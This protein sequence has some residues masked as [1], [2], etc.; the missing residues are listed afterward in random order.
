MDQGEAKQRRPAEAAQPARN[1]NRLGR[2]RVVIAVAGSIGIYALVRPLFDRFL[3]PGQDQAAIAIIVVLAS[4]WILRELYGQSRIQQSY[5]SRLEAELEL[6]RNLVDS[7]P[8]DLF[9]K[10]LDGRFIFSNRAMATRAR[11]ESD[12]DLIG[13]TDFDFFPTEIAASY[14][15]DDLGVV[16]TGVPLIGK[17]ERTLE[18]QG[19]P[20]WISTSKYPLRDGNNKIVGV[21]GISQDLTTMVERR[22]V[23]RAL[24]DSVPDFLYAKDRAGRF[25]MANRAVA[26]HMGVKSADDLLG[27]TDFEFYPEELARGFWEDEQAIMQSGRR[28]INKEEV[29]QDGAGQTK[30]TI[31]TKLC[32]RDRE[33]EVI[34]I[35]GMGHD[36]TSRKIAERELIAAREQALRASEAEHRNAESLGEAV[37]ELQLRTHQMT[38]FN[39]MGHLLD[40]C[41]T[42][43]EAC[44]V[45]AEYVQKLFPEALSGSLCLFRSSRNLLENTVEWGRP[46]KS[47]LQFAPEAC[48]G[49]RRNVP[50]WTGANGGV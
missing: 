9:A 18:N 43:T 34:G 8:D 20:Q 31:T 40:C 14:R 28:L 30:W 10:D 47:E 37:R 41:G 2:W 36:I 44:T 23:L 35:M 49:I 25:I 5:R 7:I 39:E 4:A 6:L 46:S 16:T 33:D 29:T 15:H 12:Q 45:V 3:S 11:A 1:F 48:W 42:I 50:H 13:K 22:E 32:H 21:L 27:K 17:E 26:I 24:L 38:L 19:K